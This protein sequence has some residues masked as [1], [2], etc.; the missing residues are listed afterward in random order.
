MLQALHLC[1][2]SSSEACRRWYR[3]RCPVGRWQGHLGPPVRSLS[4]M[5]PWHHQRATLCF[6]PL[7]NG[8]WTPQSLSGVL[9]QPVTSLC[10]SPSVPPPTPGAQVVPVP[11][12]VCS[13]WCWV[14]IR[15]GLVWPPG[16]WAGGPPTPS[17]AH[18]RLWPWLGCHSPPLEGASSSSFALSAPALKTVLCGLWVSQLLSGPQPCLLC[19]LSHSTG[20]RRAET[21]EAGRARLGLRPGLPVPL[22]HPE[23]PSKGLFPRLMQLRPSLLPSGSRPEGA[24]QGV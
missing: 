7:P 12:P 23:H 1:L 20:P 11:W 14:G 18:T 17:Q 10:T 3:P 22:P 8:H 6:S 24:E 5:W 15:P 21:S 16:S 9:V 19:L 2:P 4:H 13:G